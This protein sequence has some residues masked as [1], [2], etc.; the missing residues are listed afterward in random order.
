MKHYRLT[1]S[2]VCKLSELSKVEIIV[3]LYLK[4]H[5]PFCRGDRPG[6]TA[7]ARATGLAKSG[8]SAALKSL[9]AK[10]WLVHAGEQDVHAGEQDVH[11]GEQDVH[12]GEQDVHA[13][14]HPTSE[15]R[16]NTGF[17][18]SSNN[19]EFKDSKT[20]KREREAH[21]IEP[22]PNPVRRSFSTPV[23]V[24]APQNTPRSKAAQ[25]A[26]GKFSAAAADPEFF[27]FVL[28]KVRRF[29][30]PPQSPH[31]AAES[32]IAKQRPA[33]WAEFQA[34][35]QAP[36]TVADRIL[37][38]ALWPELPPPVP[39]APPTAEAQAARLAAK[40]RAFPGQRA[41][42]REECDRLGIPYGLAGPELGI[43]EAQQ[44]A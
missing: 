20:I 42:V 26:G 25:T 18:E 34:S 32:W 33:L 21:A 31:A 15:T 10:G 11:A 9:D 8:I 22:E 35:Q 38:G 7:I 3:Y 12:A 27:N 43:L 14:E 44:L 1:E 2:T 41:K 5:D 37:A 36:P 24:S 29:P 23:A 17:E 40:W 13:G 39:T 19:K 28:A 6:P 4:A 30:Q 16:L